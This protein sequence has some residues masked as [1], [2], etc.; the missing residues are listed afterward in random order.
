MKILKF[1]KYKLIVV[2]LFVFQSKIH[3]QEIESQPISAYALE[4]IQALTSDEFD[5]RGYLNDGMKK[6]AEFIANEF[7]K[8]GLKPI[9][10]SYFQEFEM[11]INLIKDARLIINGQKLNYGF[12]FI[13]RPNSKPQNFIEKKFYIFDF[14]A[15]SESLKND[16]SFIEFIENDMKMQHKKHIIFP[17]HTFEVDSLNQYYKNWPTVYRADENQNRSIFFFTEDKLIGSLSQSQD[18][19]TQFFINKNHYTKDLT[20]DHYKVDSEYIER[21]KAF[22]VLGEIKGER[23]DSTIVITAHY[24]HLGRV[25]DTIF[26]GASDNASGTAF[27]LDLAKHFSQNKP[28]YNLI[29]IAFAAEEA[30]LIGS[31]YFADNPLIELEEIKFLLNFDIMGAGEDGIQIVNSSIFTE[32]Y[33]LL[34]QINEKHRL[35][36]A[37]KK[38]GE[39]C[40]SDHCPFYQKGVPSFFTYTLGGPGHYHDPMDTAES[41]NL[42]GFEN[43]KQLFIQFIEKL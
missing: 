8:L 2:L 13:V 42:S 6:S 29:F 35:I 7:E 38:R 34:N 21:F 33:E 10:G 36:K 9:N 39:A 16:K 37:I 30:G 19:I 31:K 28:K 14:I 17:P 24:D 18:S 40:N 3:A 32:E 11:P 27:V 41:L 15:F 20:I 43:I 23:N 1:H 12:D 25:G 22:N 4:I 26:R 5:G